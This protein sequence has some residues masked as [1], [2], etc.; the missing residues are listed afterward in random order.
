[1]NEKLQKNHDF[2]AQIRYYKKE[3]NKH[4]LFFV[5]VCVVLCVCVPWNLF[6]WIIGVFCAI[7]AIFQFADVCLCQEAIQKTKK[8]QKLE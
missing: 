1:M 4:L 2:D 7:V 8:F 3:R 5:Q 6:L